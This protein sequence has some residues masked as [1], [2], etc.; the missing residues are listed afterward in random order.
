ME[1]KL[2][3]VL[4]M[5]PG[6][7]LLSVLRAWGS[8]VPWASFGALLAWFL[9]AVAVS[10]LRKRVPDWGMPALGLIFP[11][12]GIASMYLVVSI[13]HP[14]PELLEF[15]P[16]G[17]ALL[18]S[19]AVT[20]I[21]GAHLSMEGRLKKALLTSLAVLAVGISLDVFSDWLAAL[22]S[23]TAMPSLFDA[24]RFWFG[25]AAME[26]LALASLTLLFVLTAWYLAPDRHYL[27]LGMM[28]V[29][30]HFL[31]GSWLEFDYSIVGTGYARL[32]GLW[33]VFWLAMVLPAL[34]VTESA[35]RY[36]LAVLT[37]VLVIAFGGVA[38]TNALVRVRPE[39][40][41]GVLSLVHLSPSPKGSL[42][43]GLGSWRG[44]PLSRVV[45]FFLTKYLSVAAT[46]IAGYTFATGGEWTG[47]KETAE[48]STS[49]T[50]FRGG[51][52]EKENRWRNVA[53]G[54]SGGGRGDRLSG[55]EVVGGRTDRG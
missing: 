20:V 52:G 49:G 16:W 45:L 6:L 40:L 31:W 18:L 15:S 42:I 30:G 32:M 34:S 46:A 39:T 41:N 50:D 4:A 23:H 17:I 33:F 43:A 37:V 47:R 9:L 54:R 22:G 35:R 12:L 44:E 36:P 3:P 38:V 24:L 26:N 29:A 27:A 1:E 28:G 48:E 7:L 25:Y 8:K 11:I 5:V 53:S 51:S 19:A 13:F 14:T 10:Y 55:A 21:W 2:S